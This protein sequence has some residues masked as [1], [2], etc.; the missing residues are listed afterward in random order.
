[1]SGRDARG[2]RDALADEALSYVDVCR[3]LIAGEWLLIG[4]PFETMRRRFDDAGMRG[5]PSIYL[6]E[7]PSAMVPLFVTGRQIVDAYVCAGWG[8]GWAVAPADDRDLE[9]IGLAPF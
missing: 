5:V 3:V 1:M 4:V 8:S 9:R 7:N 2:V 6:G